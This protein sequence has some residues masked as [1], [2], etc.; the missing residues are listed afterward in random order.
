M[1]PGSVQQ[2]ER[3]IVSFILMTCLPVIICRHCV[4]KS[5][6]Q[7]S[8][9]LAAWLCHWTLLLYSSSSFYRKFLCI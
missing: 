2:V 4:S 8:R 6:C 1:N 9:P 5:S 7:V 3:H